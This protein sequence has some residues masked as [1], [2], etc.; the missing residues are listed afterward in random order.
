MSTDNAR[1]ALLVIDVQQDFCEGGALAVAGGNA[2]AAAVKDYLT[3]R[4]DEYELKVASQD[5][6]AAP[7]NDNCGHFALEA[8]PDFVTSWP[9]HC[10]LGTDGAQLHPDLDPQMFDVV[11]HKGTGTQSY[12][13]FEGV[14]V[15]NGLRGDRFAGSSLLAVL[16]SQGI[17]EIDLCGIATDH[18]VRASALDALGTGFKVNI[19]SDM[20]AGVF[21][22]S[23][24]AA[25][26]EIRAAG[27]NVVEAQVR[28]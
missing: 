21:P 7:P 12:S 4:W 17:T 25:L 18:C 15:T 26:E 16:R 3:Q 5:A 11:A 28:S 14:A 23:S 8:E 1:K 10:V 27:G 9:V 6:H 24:A 2:V 19:L 13:A 20:V 22:E